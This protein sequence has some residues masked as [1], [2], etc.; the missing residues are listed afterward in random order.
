MSGLAPF[1]ADV[2]GLLEA[3]EDMGRCGEELRALVDDLARSVGRL[4][5]S[6]AGEAAS[7]HRVAHDRWTGGF[8]EMQEALA[9][10]RAVADVARGNYDAAA[11]ANT[12]LWKQVR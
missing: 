5:L 2:D 4:H 6:W 8:R 12:H 9:V 10:L 3:V 1:V 7:A 11:R